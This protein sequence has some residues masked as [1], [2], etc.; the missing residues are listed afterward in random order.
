MDRTLLG[1]LVL[2]CCLLP[3]AAESQDAVAAAAGSTEGLWLGPDGQPLPFAT[4]EQALAF[5]RSAKIVSQKELT[6]GVNRPLK[7]R[8]RQDGVEANAVFRIVDI[9]RKRARLDGKLFA[10]FHDSYIY[11]C[12]AWETSRL[13]GIDNIPP[14]VRRRF[15]LTNGTMQLWVEDAITEKDRREGDVKPPEQ[16]RWMRQKQTM[17]L[18]D[19]LIYNFDRNMGNMLIDSRWKLWFIDHTRSFRKSALVEKPEK[20][21]WC[22]RGVFERL[23]ALDK[24]TLSRQLRGLVSSVAVN[25]MLKRRDK[26]VRH[27]KDRIEEIGEGAVLYD[28][29][30]PGEVP[31]ELLELDDDLPETSSRLEDPD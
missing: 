3:I 23:Q 14:C 11:E 20:I 12:A 15:E 21:F 22:E 7:V 10:D 4:E 16:L 8:L 1:L 24:K 30:A 18:F 9:Q 6:G 13:L 27:L 25:L 5:L 31:A 28:T 17:R 2:A 29:A 26:L 19:A